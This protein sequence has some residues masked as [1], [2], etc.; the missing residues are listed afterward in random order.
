VRIRRRHVFHGTVALVVLLL[1]SLSAAFAVDS[2][3]TNDAYDALVAHRVAVRGHPHGCALRGRSGVGIGP[4]VCRYDYVLGTTHF[5]ALIP[6]GQSAV[7]YVDPAD[8]SIRMSKVDFDGGPEVA[9]VDDVFVGLTLLAALVV[10][11]T[12]LAHRHRRRAKRPRSSSPARD[13]RP[14][15]PS[16]RPVSARSG[17]DPHPPQA[18]VAGQYLRLLSD[19]VLGRVAGLPSHR[20]NTSQI[21]VGDGRLVLDSPTRREVLDLNVPPSAGSP[22]RLVVVHVRRRDGRGRHGADRFLVVL[23]DQGAMRGRLDFPPGT[24][25]AISGVRSLCEEAGLRFAE[26]YYQSDRSLKAARPQWI[27]EL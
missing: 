23:D 22:R 27:T 26:E 20:Y 12:D 1:L 10:T 6:F 9:T 15:L 2:V 8:H 17:P 21:L 4:R 14:L 19:G 16:R 25:F 5:S 3:Q 7:L 18:V 13:R 24:D 11:T